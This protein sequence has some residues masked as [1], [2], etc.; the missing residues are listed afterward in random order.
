MEAR[1][2]DGFWLRKIYNVVSVPFENFS[3]A[4]KNKIFSNE[5]FEIF[6]FTNHQEKG[7]PHAGGSFS[8]KL[9]N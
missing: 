6:W 9:L 5:K 1:A 3:L 7:S 8:R 4:Y 2:Y